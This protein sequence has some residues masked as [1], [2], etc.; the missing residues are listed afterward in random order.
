[1]NNTADIN[2]LFAQESWPQQARMLSD[3]LNT[4]L[5]ERFSLAETGILIPLNIPLVA[6]MGSAE[7][8]DVD[9]RI[10]SLR[11]IGEACLQ[12]YDAAMQQH[13]RYDHERE[14]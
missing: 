8:M 7:R 11:I 4:V 10:Q 5:R 13:D 14:G 12:A 1:M 6:A 9:V 3:Y 2:R